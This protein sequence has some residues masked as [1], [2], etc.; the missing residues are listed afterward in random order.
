MA[1]RNE[2]DLFI[3]EIRTP[4]V[5]SLEDMNSGLRNA[6]QFLRNLPRVEMN[7]V[8]A[9]ATEC[10]ICQETY[11]TDGHDR[12]VVQMPQCGHR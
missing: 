5:V 4:S 1:D 12:T 3:T 2:D 11:G 8:A 7:D 6:Y 10:T 9:D